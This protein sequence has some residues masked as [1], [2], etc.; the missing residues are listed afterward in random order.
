MPAGPA[1]FSPVRPRWPSGFTKSSIPYR[2]GGVDEPRQALPPGCNGLRITKWLFDVPGR[3]GRSAV[4]IRRRPCRH[5]CLAPHLAPDGPTSASAHTRL[6]QERAKGADGG[7]H[8]GRSGAVVGSG[9]VAWD[10]T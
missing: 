2:R 10:V 5:E 7:V 9:C 6:P 1:R 4:R 8:F 3:S